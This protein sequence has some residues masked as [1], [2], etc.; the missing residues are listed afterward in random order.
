MKFSHLFMLISDDF[1]L[2]SAKIAYKGTLV[3]LL[4]FIKSDKISIN[5][6]IKS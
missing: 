3:L 5:I 4:M 2:K 1:L 6:T